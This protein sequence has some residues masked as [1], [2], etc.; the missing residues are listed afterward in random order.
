MKSH[1]TGMLFSF[2]VLTAS[3]SLAVA[4]EAQPSANTIVVGSGNDLRCRLDKGLRIT[5]AGEPIT[6]RLVEP[7]YVGTSLAIA[8]GSTIQGHVSSVSTAPLSKRT[9][10]LLKGDFTPP[11]TANVTFDHLVLSD[12]TS[13]P[14]HTDTTVGVSGV[15]R[16][17]Y[18]P[19]SQR[20]GV[21]QKVKDAAEPL[22]EPNKLQRL[23]E[24]AITS[25]PYHPEY[26]DQGTIFDAALLDPI[27]TPKPAAQSRADVD[28]PSGENY[29]RLRLLT[30]LHS[31][32]IARGASIE[33]AVSQP[34]YNSDHFLLYPAGTKLEGTVSKAKSADWM[35]KNGAL[36]FSFHSALTPDGTASSLNA[37][38][39][40]IEAAGHQDLAIG[41]EGDVKATT[42]LF[43]QLR[44]PLSLIGP[45]RAVTDSTV[46]KTA[47]SRAGEGHKGFGL[48]GAG[49]AQ[50][51]AATATGFGYFGAA[52]K[53]YDAFLAKGSDVELPVNTPIFLRVNEGPQLSSVGPSL[54]LV[55]L[56]NHQEP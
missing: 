39:T 44:A 27:T 55:D 26:L 19:K 9:G 43:T 13:L 15:K 17:K 8:E 20:P 31:Q 41:Q 28:P 56:V 2:S 37:T 21:R 10:R 5:K 16:T 48:V 23:G 29:L 42:P 47:W 11:Q 53:I 51:S 24:A 46:D 32:M 45:S 3:I 35:K 36:L 30:P 6:A 18:L 54:P 40:E 38:V 14:I 52:M 49:A 1:I 7:V 22:R 50:A 12:G 4:Q 25:L 33:A 34:Y